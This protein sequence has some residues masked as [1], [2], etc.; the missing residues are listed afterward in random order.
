VTMSALHTASALFVAKRN[1]VPQLRHRMQMLN[2]SQLTKM[3]MLEPPRI[4]RF[5]SQGLPIHHSR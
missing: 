3:F 4:A 5:E 1:L 2:W